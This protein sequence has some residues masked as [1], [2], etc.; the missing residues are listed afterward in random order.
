MLRL[1]SARFGVWAYASVL[2]W[3][4]LA[5]GTA[6]AQDPAPTVREPNVLLIVDTSGSMEY[7]TGYTGGVARYP[8]CHPDIPGASERSRWIDLVEVLTGDIEDYR[9]VA[10]D[11]RSSDFRDEY[12]L[13]GSVSPPDANYRNPYHRPLSGQ[14]AIGPNRGTAP[15]HAF[16]WWA[17]ARYPYHSPNSGPCQF[18][19]Q[20]T[21][22]IDSLGDIFRFGLMTFDTLPEQGRGYNPSGYGPLYEEGARGAW[23]YFLSQ[24]TT[25]HPVYCRESQ[26]LEVGARNGGAPPWEGKMIAFGNPNAS[27]TDN[28]DRHQRIQEVLLSTRPYGATPIAGALQDAYD[29]FRLDDSVDP[30]DPSGLVPYGPK[31]DPYVLGG[32]RKQVVILLTDG[33]PNLDLRPHCEGVSTDPLTQGP[34]GVCPFD[35][36][37]EITRRL[38]GDSLQPIDTY[39]VGFAPEITETGINCKDL[40][41]SDFNQPD[42]LCATR[43]QDRALQACCTLHRIA[44]GGNTQKAYFAEDKL[45]L[46]SK[47]SEI[48]ERIQSGGSSSAT[49]PVR[50]PGVGAHEAQGVVAFRILTSYEPI[51]SAEPNGLW[52]GNIERL[53]WTCNTESGLP[54]EQ[55]LSA[56]EGDDFTA[57]VN[58]APE[59]RSFITFEAEDIGSGQRPSSRSI[60]PNA[61]SATDGIGVLGGTQHRGT[62]LELVSSLSAGSIQPNFVNNPDLINSS[63]CSGLSAEACK[64]RVLKWALG[65]QDGSEPSR[66]PSSGECNV[67][68][69]V[70]HS[71]P[72]IVNRPQAAI[73]DE[74]YELFSLTHSK[75]PMMVYTSTND[76]FLHGFQLSANTA[77]DKPA[78][79]NQ[80]NELFAFLPPAV[81]PLLQS[82]YPKTRQKLLDGVPV[83]QDV[84]AEANPSNTHYPYHLER[85]STK[86]IENPGGSS[87]WRT[88]LVQSFGG[89]QSGYFALDIT[90]PKSHS[91]ET[92]VSGRL[93]EP[94]FLWQL[95][96]DENGAP[97]FGQGSGKP[98]ITTL[99]LQ[100]AGGE[101]SKEVAVAVLP[102]GY[103]GASTGAGCTR[104]GLENYTALP[105]EFRPRN[106][107][108]CYSSSSSAAR[109]LTIVRLD[110]GEVLKTFRAETGPFPTDLVEITNLPSPLTGTPAAYPAGPGA[111][112]DRIFIGD[113]DGALWRVDVS[114]ADPTQ[115]TMDL[116]FDAFPSNLPTGDTASVGRPIATAPVLSV[117][118][119]GQI[120]IAFATGD[121]GLSGS[122]GETHHVW[123]LREV[124]K[125]GRFIPSVNWYETL[126]NGEHVLGPLELMAETVYFSTWKPAEM[127]AAACEGGNSTVWG[128]HY[129]QPADPEKP[130]DGGRGALTFQGRDPARYQTATELGLEPGTV[131]FGVA[132]EFV[133][134]C[135]DTSQPSDNF[136]GGSRTAVSRPS[137]SQMQLVFQTTGTATSGQQDL[138]FKTGFEALNLA[139]PPIASTIESWAA[140][141]E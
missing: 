50:S 96:T 36:P 28:Q 85:P 26:T 54:E 93:G 22:L 62:A 29:F 25:G 42:G 18:N 16:E 122:T 98:L 10:V 71:T 104:S 72:V 63:A 127:E 58:R 12:S 141:L 103:G 15:A 120:T 70:M 20:G 86:A 97:L 89:A 8:Q 32:C 61:L 88:I 102:G 117:D 33:E 126:L 106:Q 78:T 11:R 56:D 46:R 6:Q 52:R 17:P 139:A 87:T 121:Q 111:V 7:T 119:R 66:C 19:Q 2:G 140:L 44:Y 100:G 112:A 99:F 57:N 41:L 138:N 40:P 13:P 134:S 79:P 21:G 31:D 69:D 132:I 101:G 24:P 67:V 77:E 43:P 82:Q 65:L 129:L 124:L 91:E 48:V 115:W 94:R 90:E 34:S 5:S 133:P 37:E 1:T 49:Q 109:S 45:A 68:G 95:T 27:S 84:I 35:R 125:D 3:G 30:L 73:Q 64:E 55:A 75:R 107:V 80:N 74:T 38:A 92:T 105:E 76:G 4:L 130:G 23:S 39:V 110:S 118:N 83:V 123:S 59:A 128:L 116:F 14:C 51:R 135:Y 108:N 81:L 136:T 131:I 53:R 114:N 60:R 47:L 113:Q 137:A 9:C